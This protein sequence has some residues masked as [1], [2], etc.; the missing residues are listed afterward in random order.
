MTENKI[1]QIL[2]IRKIG[3]RVNLPPSETLNYFI[4]YTLTKPRIAAICVIKT[5]HNRL[6]EV[7][8]ENQ[9]ITDIK[10]MLKQSELCHVSM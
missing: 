10:G 7:I 1:L 8:S 9:D 5:P 3:R 6:G 4:L 2:N